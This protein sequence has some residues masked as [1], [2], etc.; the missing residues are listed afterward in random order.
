PRVTLQDLVQSNVEAVGRLTLASEYLRGR[1]RGFV[2]PLSSL[3]GRIVALDATDRQRLD[4]PLAAK[5]AALENLG[6]SDEKLP[7]VPRSHRGLA[8]LRG[9]ISGKVDRPYDL[10][11][12]SPVVPQQTSARVA[13]AAAADNGTAALLIRR[14]GYSGRVSGGN[15]VPV[16]QAQVRELVTVDDVDV[17]KVPASD[18]VALTLGDIFRNWGARNGEEKNDIARMLI[19]DGHVARPVLVSGDKGDRPREWLKRWLL[20]ANLLADGKLTIEPK[21]LPFT[22]GKVLSFRGVPVGEL[23]RDFVCLPLVNGHWND[24]ATITALWNA[25]ARLE[26]LATWCR[27]T[28]TIALCSGPVLPA[29]LELLRTATAPCAGV[30]KQYTTASVPVQ[31]NGDQVSL[32][33]P[34]AG[35]GD[36]GARDCVAATAEAFGVLG[37]QP[38]AEEM[39]PAVRGVVEEIARM[40]VSVPRLDGGETRSVVFAELLSGAARDCLLG[41]VVVDVDARRAWRLDSLSRLVTSVTGELLT[42]NVGCFRTEQRTKWLTPLRREYLPLLKSGAVDIRSEEHGSELRVALTIH[43]RTFIE[44]YAASRIR[45]INPLLFHWPASVASPSASLTVL[46]DV[47]ERRFGPQALYVVMHDREARAW[48]LS[49]LL[50]QRHSLHYVP[51]G[52]NVPYSLSFDLE[53]RDVGFLKI[54]RTVQHLGDGAQRLAVDFGT[55]AT[56]V[57]VDGNGKTEILDLLAT[58]SDATA[59]VW[60]GSE[61]TAFQWY[62]TRSLDPSIREKRRA[63]S[64]LVYLGSLK[65]ARPPQPLYG[66]HVLLDQDDWQWKNGDASLMFDIKWTR[67]RAY[68]ETYLIHHL[69]QCIGAAL[70]KGILHS[71]RLSVIFTMPLRQ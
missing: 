5:R 17:S 9:W 20:L 44:S 57:A 35:A 34:N 30:G 11:K 43:G 45:A 14:I 16:T 32:P 15:V 29:W 61:L 49:P 40:A 2:L 66:D 64:A 65:E 58:A 54:D 25:G 50:G 56:V 62:G 51:A 23:S 48:T 27:N 47:Q 37:A 69:E 1:Y 41:E 36:A 21:P 31:W 19:D 55:S 7:V 4:G 24:E 3:S 28:A 67:E 71:R 13:E 52:S 42:E 39:S 12:D 63:P 10:W 38:A 8:T 6:V 46:F 60:K 68:R 26:K 70:S 33:L 59:E 18:A 53:H 22:G